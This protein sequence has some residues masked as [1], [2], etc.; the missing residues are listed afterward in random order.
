[1]TVAIWGVWGLFAMW[2]KWKKNDQCY[3]CVSC[4]WSVC[5]L[6][7]APYS[8]LM[9]EICT[10]SQSDCQIKSAEVWDKQ[11]AD[12]QE[13]NEGRVQAKSWERASC[14]YRMSFRERTRNITFKRGSQLM[15]IFK[16]PVLLP[17]SFLSVTSRV[18]KHVS[19]NLLLLRSWTN[20]HYAWDRINMLYKF[21][22]HLVF[23]YLNWFTC[24]SLVL[25]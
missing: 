1:M 17:L 3:V 6:S 19:E 15:P 11:N 21:D 25:V 2:K 12:S 16:Y 5:V 20:F 23:V 22:Q 10:C 9:R 18:Q 13:Y 8:S 24:V 14:P 4:L 7:S